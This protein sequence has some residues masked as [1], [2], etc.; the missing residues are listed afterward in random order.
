[1]T[2]LGLFHFFLQKKLFLGIVDAMS[3]QSETVAM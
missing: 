1:M 3:Q 2:D